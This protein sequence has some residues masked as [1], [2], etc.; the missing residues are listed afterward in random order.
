MLHEIGHYIHH[1]LNAHRKRHPRIFDIRWNINLMVNLSKKMKRYF[2]F[3]F[4]KES[5]K[6]WE[7]DLWAMC[8]FVYLAKR[9][10]CRDELT[11][12]LNRHPEKKWM[13]RLVT[14]VIVYCD[15]KTRISSARKLWGD[16]RRR[17][18]EQLS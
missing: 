8:A 13:Y 3:M 5:G 11:S 1:V 10:G 17:M 9:I 12:F 16:A 7:A 2:R 6:E 14:S 15:C 18:N 4:H